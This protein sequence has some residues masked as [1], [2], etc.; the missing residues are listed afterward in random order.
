MQVTKITRLIVGTVMMLFSGIIYAWS[1]LK[2]PLHTELG[3]SNTALG[4]NFTITLCCFCIGGLL[5]GIMTKKIS[6]RSSVLIAA[7]LAFSGFVIAS[8]VNSNII[9]LYLS[10]G[11]LLGLGIGIAYNVVI[12]TITGWF[13]HRRA[14]ASGVLMMGFGASSLL[15]GTLTNKL[16]GNIGWRST[17]FYLGIAVLI[18]LGLGSIFVVPSKKVQEKRELQ[19]NI[20]MSPGEALSSP[21]FWKFYTYAMLLASVGTGVISFAKDIALSSGVSET[22]AATSVG[23]LS[24]CNGLGRVVTGGIYDK[25]GGSKTMISANVFAIASVLMVLAALR[26]SSSPL[27]L[28][29]L[30]MIGF[31]YGT[32]PPILTGFLN[33]RFGSRSFSVIFSFANTILIPASF[34]ST[35][36]A[37]I[38]STK[39]NYIAVFLL[40]L[41]MAIVGLGINISI[42]VPMKR[43]R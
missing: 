18:V 31:A 35:I 1:I 42:H 32:M 39:G 41:A 27:L 28:I 20:D 5:G 37:S 4:L 24:V 7:I 23:M 10:Y 6:P 3:W 12:S 25:A 14:T 34:M 29:G 19:G 9:I 13:S 26:T 11:G 33:N 2:A 43:A 30:C 17:Y 21:D 16:I 40:F 38:I 15:I 8:R 36:S 22:L